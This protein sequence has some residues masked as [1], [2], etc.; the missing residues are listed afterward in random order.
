[1]GTMNDNKMLQAVL[2]GQVSI[3]NEV[4][5]IKNEMK[6]GFEKVNKRLDTIGT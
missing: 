5:L 3:K 1:M 6:K 2:D 4:T